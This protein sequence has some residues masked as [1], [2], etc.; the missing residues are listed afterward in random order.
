[1][2]EERLNVLEQKLAHDVARIEAKVDGI[3]ETMQA[4]VRVEERQ[5]RSA[6]RLAELASAMK[7]HDD[8]LRAVELS[9]PNELDKRIG[10]IEKVLPQLVES[11]N[12]MMAGIIACVGLLGTSLAH[13]VLR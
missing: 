2:S 6:E 12:W 10:L 9:I 1:M 8:R 11:R 3:A 4:L 5:A 7:G 13:Q